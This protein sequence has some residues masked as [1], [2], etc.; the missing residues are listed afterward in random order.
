MQLVREEL[1]WEETIAD[2]FCLDI[3]WTCCTKSIQACRHH[4][5]TILYHFRWESLQKCSKQVSR[6][7]V[8]KIALK[9]FLRDSE[10][11]RRQR[12]SVRIFLAAGRRNPSS[13]AGV[14]D[15]TRWGKLRFFLRLPQRSNPKLLVEAGSTSRRRKAGKPQQSHTSHQA[16]ARKPYAS[17]P[18]LG[19]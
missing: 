18:S 17:N 3:Q 13:I 6:G 14:T 9:N 5:C 10:G 16:L 2:A 11:T 8:A 4:R 7:M 19:P 15:H 1:N 12:R